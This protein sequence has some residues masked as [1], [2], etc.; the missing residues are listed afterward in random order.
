MPGGGAVKLTVA[1]YRTPNGLDL[2]GRGLLPDVHGAYAAAGAA[3]AVARHLPTVIDDEGGPRLVACTVERRGR[4]LVAQ[5]FF[6]EGQQLALGPA[7]GAGRAPPASSSWWST[8]RQR[9][10]ASS[11]SARPT[12][13]EHVLRALLLE[14]GLAGEWP[15]A[16]LREARRA[17]GQA[18]ERRRGETI[19]SSSRR[20]RSTRPPRAISTMRSASSRTATAI[21]AWCTSPTLRAT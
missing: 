2:H 16:A 11:G 6:E 9:A 19:C 12:T 20:S 14:R 8:R 15:E 10:R 21:R 5:P 13:S 3:V 1:E 7:L 18:A 4:F 17:A